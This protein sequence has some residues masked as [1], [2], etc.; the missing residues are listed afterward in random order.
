MRILFCGLS[1]IPN[2]ASASINRYIAIGQAVSSKHEVIFI[3]RFPLFKEIEQ[4]SSESNNLFKVIDATNIKYRPKSFI[5]RNLLK[6][7]SFLYEYWAIRK[8]HKEQKIDW[9]NIYTQYFGILIFYY[10]LSKIF[11][12]KT[13]LHY[14]EFR[15]KFIDRIWFYRIND[16]LFDKFA[17]FFL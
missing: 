6:L 4:Q 14:V 8:I 10:Y 13:I 16:L 1:G 12:F 17:V 11:N 3:N 9:L 15:S 2:K 7:A 5:K